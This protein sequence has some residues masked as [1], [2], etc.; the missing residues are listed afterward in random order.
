MYGA[1]PVVA[2][3]ARDLTDNLTSLVKQIDDAVA[4]NDKKEMRAFLVLL[5]EDADAAEPK[6]KELAEKQGI[7]KVP[8]TVFEGEAGPE[9]Y[10][11]AKDA[12]VTVL[13]WKGL[14]VKTNHAFAKGKLD[15]KSVKTVVEDT[16]SILE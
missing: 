14:E 12:D 2:I 15:A 6:L 11:I 3:F 1:R 10:K 7:K 9:S 16:K 13:M 5:T 4:K 8:L